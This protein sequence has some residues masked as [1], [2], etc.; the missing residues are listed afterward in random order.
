MNCQRAALLISVKLGEIFFGAIILFLMYIKGYQF[1]IIIIKSS[2]TG[3]S[4]ENK[5]FIK[6]FR[7]WK[8]GKKRK[9]EEQIQRSN[10]R[11]TAPLNASDVPVSNKVKEDHSSHESGPP[12]NTLQIVMF[13]TLI[14]QTLMWAAAAAWNVE[15]WQKQMEAH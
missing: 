13:Y 11:F 4:G 10:Q 14:L 9:T 6:C 5:L 8:T 12:G 7:N 3:L 2:S 1:D 15:L